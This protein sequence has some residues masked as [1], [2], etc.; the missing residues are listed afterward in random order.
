MSQPSVLFRTKFGTQSSAWSVRLMLAALLAFAS[1]I[2]LWTNPPARTPLDWIMLALGYPALSALLLEIAARYR[3]RDAFGVLT[4][5]GVY[6]M[7]N[8]LIL[9][10]DSALIDVPRTLITRA[11][12]AH[13]AAGLV[14]LALFLAL[15][16]GKPRSRRGLIVMIVLAL[17]IG[18][19]WGTWARW[20]PLVFSNQPETEL[21][22]LL[23]YAGI[24][25][26]LIALALFLTRRVPAAPL[27]LRLDARGWAFTLIVLGGLLVI[28]LLQSEIDALSLSIIVTLTVFSVMII[29]FQK[30]SKGATLLDGIGSRPPSARLMAV[31]M[32]AFALA[33]AVGYS[34][35]RGSEAA[36]DPLALISA[37]FTAFGLIWLPAVSIVLGARAFSR[38]AR[39]MN[40]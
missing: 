18:V 17:G 9:N 1:E 19:A 8:G 21:W 6:G 28:H 11:M 29:W 33:G 4:L 7:L 12:G 34:L 22:L 5:A 35:P 36:S 3:L 32:V 23:L 40:L 37:L 31:V 30:R 20:S 38:Q 13:A 27:D 2:V 25:V 15:T 24:G 16:G 14:A 39:A 10:P 26:G